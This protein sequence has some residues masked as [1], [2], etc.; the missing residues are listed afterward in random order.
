QCTEQLLRRHRDAKQ[1]DQQAWSNSRQIDSI[2]RSLERLETTAAEIRLKPKPATHF[3]YLRT[4]AYYPDYVG[5]HKKLS[6]K[7]QEAFDSN[8]PLQLIDYIKEKSENLQNYLNRASKN[9]SNSDYQK[10]GEII[11]NDEKML[12]YL[13]CEMILE[14][15]NDHL[16]KQRDTYQTCLENFDT[17]KLN[18]KEITSPTQQKHVAQQSYEPEYKPKPKPKHDNDFEM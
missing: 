13:K 11:K 9:L 6:D 16:E 17:I 4:D 18:I 7:Q 10:I 14:P 3:S 1:A 2:N 12:K 8:K 5:Q 15:Q